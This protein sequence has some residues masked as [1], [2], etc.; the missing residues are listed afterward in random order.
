M[1]VRLTHAGVDDVAQAL[2]DVLTM[3]LDVEFV[4]SDRRTWNVSRREVWRM[5]AE[6]LRAKRAPG[7]LSSQLIDYIASSHNKPR[8]TL[9]HLAVV[10]DEVEILRRTS[11][12]I[13]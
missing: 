12:D 13:R 8:K 7:S 4:G 2:V 3:A 11:S 9:R 6:E 5:A 10:L 1:S